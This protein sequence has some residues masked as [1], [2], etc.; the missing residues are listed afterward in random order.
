MDESTLAPLTKDYKAAEWRA[1][2][3][4]AIRCLRK[5][6]CF[7]V[8]PSNVRDSAPMSKMGS[9]YK[10]CYEVIMKH[11]RPLVLQALGFLTLSF[12]GLVGCAPQCGARLKEIKL[13]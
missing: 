1:K 10:A 2:D 9:V 6:S 4:L 12:F 8:A 3:S 11:P 7:M 13:N 5:G